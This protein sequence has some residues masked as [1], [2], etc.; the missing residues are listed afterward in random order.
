MIEK[1]KKLSLL[2]Y[3]NSRETFLNNLQN[4]GVVHLEAD[5]S[6]QN[7][8]II[9]NNDE[10]AKLKKVQGI[11]KDLLKKSKKKIWQEEKTKNIDQIISDFNN[12]Y[13]ALNVLENKLDVLKKEKLTLLPWGVFNPEII[14]KLKEKEIN[15]KFY[16]LAKSNF[17]KL[18]LTDKAYEIISATKG[19]IYFVVFYKSEE[20]FSDFNIPEDKFIMKNTDE[21][22]LEIEKGKNEIEIQK[23]KVSLYIKYLNIISE[24]VQKITDKLA[25]QITDANLSNE[26]KGKVLIIKGWLPLRKLKKAESFLK[27]QDVAYLLEDPQK[28]DNVPIL[29][30]NNFISRLFEPIMKIFSLPSYFELDTTVFLAPFF[31]LFFGL[32]QADIGYGLFL[33]TI[34]LLVSIFAKNKTIRSLGL[35]GM[36]LSIMVVIGG[37]WLNGIFGFSATEML[38]DKYRILPESFRKF[39]ILSN[40]NDAMVF[41]LMLGIIQILFAYILRIVN[42]VRNGGIHAGLLPLGNFFLLFGLVSCVVGMS[43]KGFKIGPFKIGNIF[44]MFKENISL[45]I[46]GNIQTFAFPFFIGI[47]LIV[48]GTLL[49]LFFNNI[50]KKIYIRPLLGLWEMYGNITGI[51]GDILSYLRLFALGLS[52]GLLGGAVNNIAFMAKGDSNS[53]ASFII[54]GLIMVF[55]HSLNLLL[56]ILGSFVHPLRLTFVEFYKNIGFT[57]GGI[58]YSPFNLKYKKK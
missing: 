42:Q 29:L 10:C 19:K 20:D 1:M 39:T 35:L 50:D 16:S 24:E 53:I 58:E 45:D 13:E 54:V 57:G 51:P 32:C 56:S 52:G 44:F 17:K 34:T 6:V 33:L 37:V 8:E 5:K 31:A 2:I 12:D 18:D 40:Q 28:T 30:R 27:D 22:D 48:L 26:V 47:L 41:A 11:L 15:I 4:L 23:K 46:G 49:I 36:I 43:G 55:G 7:D 3:H 14:S 25:Y 38:I 9:K 21:L